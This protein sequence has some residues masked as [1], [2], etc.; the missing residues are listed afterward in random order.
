[1]PVYTK[2]TVVKSA[3]TKLRGRESADQE[4]EIC[5]NLQ[6]KVTGVDTRNATTTNLAGNAEGSDSIQTLKLKLKLAKAQM[7]LATVNLRPMTLDFHLM[8]QQETEKTR[9]TFCGTW[10]SVPLLQK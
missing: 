1:M 5:G 7:E 6:G 4:V 10:V 2:Q 8:F 9:N 3:S